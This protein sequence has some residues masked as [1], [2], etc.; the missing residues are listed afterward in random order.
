MS[1]NR[2]I[3]KNNRLP[4]HIPE[5]MQYFKKVTLGKP[6]IMGRQT[7]ASMKDKP[8]PHRQN[9]I[10][11]KDITSFFPNCV[12]VHSMEDALTA[13]KPCEEVM[14]IGGAKIYEQFLPIA[15]RLYLS[16]IH[17]IVDGDTFFPAFDE[18]NWQ[19]SE[20]EKHNGFTTQVFDRKQA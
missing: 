15:H 6:V 16:T 20:E 3:G 8:L 7:F 12:T 11:T 1:E 17:Q 4:W 14:V 18:T 13:A 9:I 10:L 19:L 5:E 2:V